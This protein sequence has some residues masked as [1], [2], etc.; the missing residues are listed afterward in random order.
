MQTRV[1]RIDYFHATVKDRPGEA[2]EIL[3]RL[4][5]SGV[6]LLA[7]SAVPCGL[8]N[9]QLVLFPEDSNNLARA[10]ADSDLVLIGPHRAF[11]IQ[12]D[13]KL[14]AISDIHRRLFEASVNVYA[15]NGVTDGRGGYGYIFYVKPEEYE[16][17]AHALDL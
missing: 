13:D 7:F 5:A 9:T 3:S 16:T 12:G 10:A 17:A 6:N 2:F 15:S 14:G 1:R 8:G 4:R 11:L